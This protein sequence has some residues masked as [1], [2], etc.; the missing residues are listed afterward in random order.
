MV[1]CG[2]PQRNRPLHVAPDPV[3]CMRRHPGAAD[4]S[5]ATWLIDVGRAL[6]SFR[7]GEYEFKSSK[8]A[9]RKPP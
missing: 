3:C 4:P 5:I 8:V 7:A 9:P 2:L 6:Q 1:G